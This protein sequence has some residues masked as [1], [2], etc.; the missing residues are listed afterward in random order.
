MFSDPFA[1]AGVPDGDALVVNYSAMF[2][3]RRGLSRYFAA[4]Q[5]MTRLRCPSWTAYQPDDLARSTVYFPLV[6][7]LVGGI[8]AG[9]VAVVGGGQLARMMAP[10][11]TALGVHLRVLVEDPASSA[12][13]VIPDAPVGAASAE[14][15]IRAL[16]AGPGIATGRGN[17]G[18][19]DVLTF[20]R[21]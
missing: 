15:A 18:P 16:V 9:V 6:G 12:A 14:A 21:R 17:D 20:G 1:G 5:L 7:V 13:Q 10:A 19:A 3:L 11:A 8:A 4:Q 2:V